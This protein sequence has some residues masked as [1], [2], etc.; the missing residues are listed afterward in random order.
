[1]FHVEPR[2]TVKKTIRDNYRLEVFPDLNMILVDDAH[3]DAIARQTL[4]DI[5]KAI[6]RHVDEVDRVNPQW[7]TRHECSFCGREW[8][9]LT[10][11]QAAQDRA[12]GFEN[13][14]EGQPV[15]CTKAVEEF[16]LD[17]GISNVPRET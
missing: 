14:A 4:R 12:D 3:K 9:V 7:D 17:S 1:M 8:E 10:A 16:Q 13:A 6:L 15:C 5:K 2:S 11:A